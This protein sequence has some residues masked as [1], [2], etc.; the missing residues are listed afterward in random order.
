LFIIPHDAGPGRL[1]AE[2]GAA[3]PDHGRALAGLTLILAGLLLGLAGLV[4][5]RRR[6]TAGAAR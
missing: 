3:G 2:A 5:E 4:L 1:L 6:V